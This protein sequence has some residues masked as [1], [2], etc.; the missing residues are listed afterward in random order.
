MGRYV[1]LHE[2]VEAGE[3]VRRIKGLLGLERGES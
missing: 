1:E 2:G 3:A